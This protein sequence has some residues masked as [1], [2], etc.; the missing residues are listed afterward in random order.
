MM[1]NLLIAII[2]LISTAQISFAQKKDVYNNENYNFQLSLPDGWLKPKIEETNKKDVI[3]YAFDH[4]K[5]STSQILLLAFKIESVKDLDNFIY[6]LE[7][8]ATLNIPPKSGDYTSFDNGYYD[9]KMALYKDLQFT[10]LIY[11]YRTK[12]ADSKENYAYMLRFISTNYTTKAEKQF[13]EIAE[14]FKIFDKK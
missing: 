5:D 9:G 12:F 3:S 6:V 8:D 11:Y 14:N 7:K 1:R 13:K 2:L 4:K 10:E